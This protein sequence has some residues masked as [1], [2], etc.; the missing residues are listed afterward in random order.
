MKQVPLCIF[1]E[2][3]FDHFPDG[4]RVL[5][6]APFNVAWHLQAFGLA[7]RFISR[8]G[9][10][11]EGE[12]VLAAMR[13]WGMDTQA[14]QIDHRLP[15]GRVSVQ[16]ADDEPSY[17]IVT[18]VAYDAIEFQREQIPAGSFIYHGTLAI[19]SPA[20]RQTLDAII[21][22]TVP[23]LIFLDVNLRPPWWDA[24][25]V[26]QRISAADW[27]KLNADELELL[28]ADGAGELLVERNLNGLIVT[29]GADGAQAWTADGEK[30]MVRPAASVRLIDTVGAGDAFTAVAML[31]I[32]SGWPLATTLERAQTFASQI[33]GRRGATVNDRDFYAPL[34]AAWDLPPVTAG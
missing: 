24:D 15:T 13:D 32:M 21:R 22:E 31:G 7:P 30:C 8:I 4:K 19:R 16:I 20:S 12:S 1:G 10:D 2:V 29:L 18:N 5:G 3:L 6:G 27:V 28:G 33:V 25:G 17:D 11:D 14:I 26:I 23:T 9:A 34:L